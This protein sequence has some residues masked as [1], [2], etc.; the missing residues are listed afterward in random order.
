[1]KK[2]KDFFCALKFCCIFEE[3]RNFMRLSNTLQEKI[4][5]TDK[6]GMIL[7]KFQSLE[8]ILAAC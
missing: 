3:V 1:M 6:Y 4:N 7:S 5:S 8:K 2:F